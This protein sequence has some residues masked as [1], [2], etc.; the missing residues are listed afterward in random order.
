M[1]E[2]SEGAPRGR[3][4]CGAN[5]RV[6]ERCGAG[7]TA[8]KWEQGKRDG[9]KIVSGKA[10]ERSLENQG[11]ASQ[12]PVPREEG[13]LARCQMPD[14]AHQIMDGPLCPGGL[15]T[16]PALSPYRGQNRHPTESSSAAG[17]QGPCKSLEHGWKCW[18]WGTA[19]RGRGL[20]FG[21]S[22]VSEQSDLSLGFP[23]LEKSES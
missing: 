20:G 18:G 11:L 8:P 23:Q 16:S 19:G 22:S 6:Q 12:C 2:G 9:E 15:W 14:S 7:I 13:C 4:G 5:P 3:A 17:D 1:E 21:S 10:A